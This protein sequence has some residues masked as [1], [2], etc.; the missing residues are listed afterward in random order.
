MR[1]KRNEQPHT[2][3]VI[4]S[5]TIIQ[6]EQ[7]K[8]CERELRATWAL[9]Q[10]HGERWLYCQNSIISVS[11]LG[12]LIHIFSIGE[13]SKQEQSKATRLP[14]YLG[15][16]RNTLMRIKGTSRD[17]Q[18]DNSSL[19]HGWR[20]KWQTFSVHPMSSYKVLLSKRCTGAQTIGEIFL[21]IE[22]RDANIPDIVMVVL[23]ETL[24]AKDFL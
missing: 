14:S 12:L 23:C 15:F 6:C 18:E 3:T 1:W 16:T 8:S 13:I 11:I 24:P 5:V 7:T 21:S 10:L 22:V 9:R 20:D 19:R 2:T 4:Q 17:W